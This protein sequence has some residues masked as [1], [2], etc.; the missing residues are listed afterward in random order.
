MYRT[1]INLA[2]GSFVGGLSGYII[3]NN[4]QSNLKIFAFL[5]AAPILLFVPIYVS[6]Y[7]D[8]KYISDFLYQAFLGAM[9]SVILIILTLLLLNVN[10]ILALLVNFLLS[11]LAVYLYFN[12]KIY[13]IHI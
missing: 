5:W 13:L 7:K 4:N 6:Y 11:I 9:L 3:E 12:Y 1:F 10:I 2:I 8:K